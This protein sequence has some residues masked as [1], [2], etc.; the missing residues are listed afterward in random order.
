MTAFQKIG[1]PKV[2][3]TCT[4]GVM[5]GDP[6]VEGTR[7]PAETVLACVNAG[8]SVYEIDRAYPYLPLGAVDAVV[9][10]AQA[11]GLDV[12]LPLRRVPDA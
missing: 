8:M 10:W 3:I 11:K 4:P 1:M 6:C 7:V 2:A 12:A 9:E 5:S